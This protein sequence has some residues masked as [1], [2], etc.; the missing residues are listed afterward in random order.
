MLLL[1]SGIWQLNQSNITALLFDMKKS[2]ILFLSCLLTSY[3]AFADFIHPMDFDSKTQKSR[4][5]KIIKDRVRKDYCEGPI[6]MC[7]DTTLRM[8]EKENLEAF[9]KASQA[10]NRKV[11][12]RVIKDYC[13]SGLDMCSYYNIWMMYEENLKASE[14]SLEW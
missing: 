2:T 6:D 13:S 1:V 11:M 8:M 9:K 12:D 5:I 7:Q 3:S 10:K 4:V 14:D